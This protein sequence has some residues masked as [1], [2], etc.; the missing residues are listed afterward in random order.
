MSALSPTRAL[1]TG[2]A[3]LNHAP[4]P[5]VLGGVGMMIATVM[6][7]PSISWSLEHDI[8]TRQTSTIWTF[9]GVEL[10]DPTWNML[11]IA[12][13]LVAMKSALGALLWVLIEP[14]YVAVQVAA[15]AHD[16][17]PPRTYLNGLRATPRVA[18]TWGI[19]LVLIG[20]ALAIGVAPGLGVSS[21][22]Y[23]ND[24][25]F[26]QAA[27]AV[28][29]FLGGALTTGWLGTPLLFASRCAL[30]E[31]RGPFDAVARSWRLARGHRWSI[32]LLAVWIVVYRTLAFAIGCV[33]CCMSHLVLSPVVQVMTDTAI[34]VAFQTVREADPV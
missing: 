30:L 34:T 21:L 14:G 1:R 29:V 19:C 5:L 3:A 20:T 22:A 13:T 15:I 16:V 12:F 11:A 7:T 33:T 10:G 32:F 2:L 27:G 4:V 9:Q 23:A 24:R 6:V 28:L 31:E 18:A 17:L 26:V 8:A 25:P